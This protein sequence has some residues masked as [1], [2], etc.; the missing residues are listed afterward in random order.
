MSAT[1]PTAEPFFIIQI[2]AT[3]TGGIYGLS[4]RS[5]SGPKTLSNGENIEWSPVATA[6]G[7]QLVYLGSD[8][9]LPAMPF[10][11][12]LGSS[13]PVRM[14]AADQLPKDFPSAKLVVPQQVIFKAADGETI[15]GQLF[16]PTAAK[17]G[18]KM[19]AIV[20][21]HGGPIGRCCLGFITCITITTRTR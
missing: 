3:S 6:D 18:A 20:F 16:M 14:L 4:R 12:T 11:M 15:H 21:M 2:A 9:R 19:P 7:A 5:G 8:A 17:A 1:A 10:A 13:R